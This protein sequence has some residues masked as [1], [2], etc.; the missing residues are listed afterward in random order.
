MPGWDELGI[1]K[2][3]LTQRIDPIRDKTIRM[4]IFECNFLLNQRR[5]LGFTDEFA[6]AGG[7]N[8]QHELAVKVVSPLG[9]DDRLA[10]N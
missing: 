5:N 3:K 2:R 6:A 1:K 9:T 10:V 7:H 8:A 4:S